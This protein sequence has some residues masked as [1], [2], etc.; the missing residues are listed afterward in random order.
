MFSSTDL[1]RGTIVNRMHTTVYSRARCVKCN[2]RMKHRTS[3]SKAMCLWSLQSVWMFSTIFQGWHSC[4]VLQFKH[5][6]P[7]SGQA[8]VC[9]FTVRE[10]VFVLADI[11]VRS[12]RIFW[13]TAS[14]IYSHKF[15]NKITCKGTVIYL[16]T[17]DCNVSGCEATLHVS[18]IPFPWPNF[19]CQLAYLYLSYLTC[20]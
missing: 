17:C 16:R 9:S 4:L 5:C 20:T 7:I 14:G 19:G 18:R 15:E 13:M 2:L 8:V 12:H 11:S 1:R 3:L 10:S 6:A